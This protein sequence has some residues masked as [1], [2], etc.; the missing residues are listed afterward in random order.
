MKIVEELV[1]VMGCSPKRIFIEITRGNDIKGKKE[2]SHKKKLSTL[3]KAIDKEQ[4]IWTEEIAN[5]P[6]QEFKSKKLYLYCL[7]KG[8][9]MYSDVH[10]SLS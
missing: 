10:F 4:K 1:S 2:I 5:K 7:Q 6:E 8:K 9:C 3:Y